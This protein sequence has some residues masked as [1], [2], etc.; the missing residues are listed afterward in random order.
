MGLDNGNNSV[1]TQELI[2][3]VSCHV[4][5]ACLQPNGISMLNAE[6]L[7]RNLQTRSTVARKD[8]KY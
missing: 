1:G 7:N 3:R 2:V 6:S 8:M 5:S 4:V